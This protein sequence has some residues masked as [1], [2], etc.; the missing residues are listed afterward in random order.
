MLDN[1]AAI[2]QFLPPSNF[3][4]DTKGKKFSGKPMDKPIFNDEQDKDD[5]GSGNDEE[6]DDD[7]MN[8][9]PDDQDDLSN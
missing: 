2:S 4:L 9:I 8:S 3:E 5:D 6:E 1:P 7:D